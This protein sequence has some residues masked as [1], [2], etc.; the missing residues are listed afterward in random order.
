M[1]TR[2]T[3]HLDRLYREREERY[4]AGVL[5][6]VLGIS[7]AGN[8]LFPLSLVLAFGGMSF[9]QRI[10]VLASTLCALLNVVGGFLLLY[11]GRRRLAT[12]FF[13]IV[14]WLIITLSSIPF[15]L[16]GGWAAAVPMMIV[17]AAFLLTWK[18]TLALAALFVMSL[19]AI[20][21]LQ[22]Y[23]IPPTPPA[24]SDE[25]I[26]HLGLVVGSTLVTG[27]VVSVLSGQ[28][29]GL[30]EESL[31]WIRRMHAIFAVGKSMSTITDFKEMLLAVV[32]QIQEGFDF[33]HV[34]IFLIQKDGHELVLRASTA[35]DVQQLL[36]VL[37]KPAV[38]KE[39]VIGRAALGKAVIINDVAENSLFSA[40]KH[41]PH[42]QSE[43][44][45]PMMTGGRVLGVLDVMSTSLGTFS[46]EGIR[47]LQA[48]AN[49]IAVAIQTTGEAAPEVAILE[50][51]D[52]VFCASREIVGA[53]DAEA[54]IATLRKRVLTTFDHIS[55]VQFQGGFDEA[56]LEELAVWDRDG[57]APGSETPV[58][59]CSA[60]D[61][62]ALVISNVFDLPEAWA[63]HQI[64]LRDRL[65]LGSVGIFPLRGRA[66]P[67]GYLLVGKRQ[68]H[69][70]SEREHCTLLALSGQIALLLE[71][72]L[73]QQ[74]FQ[75]RT[76]RLNRLNAFF[77][78]VVAVANMD[79]LFGVL[80]AHLASMIDYRYL[81]LT[82]QESE[83]TDARTVQLR[84]PDGHPG[85]I[86]TISP[87]GSVIEQALQEEQVIVAT[88]VMDLPDGDIWLMVGVRALAIAP[89]KTEEGTLGTVNVGREEADS[90]VPEEAALLGRVGAQVA[91]AIRN[92]RLLDQTQASM[93]DITSLLLASQ[94][95]LAADGSDDII[96]AF[97]EMLSGKAAVD[98][99]I[100]LQGSEE[101][102]SHFEVT[103]VWN[104]TEE[105]AQL[106]GKVGERYPIESLP[107]FIQGQD[108]CEP[109]FCASIEDDPRLNES[110]R[111][112]LRGMGVQSMIRLPMRRGQLWLGEALLISCG[113]ASLMDADVKLYQTIVDQATFAL[114]NARLVDR[115]SASVVEATMLYST[116]LSVSIAK[117]VEEIVEVALSQLVTLNDSTRGYL[118]L[119]PP[120]PTLRSEKI[121]L[122]AWWDEGQIHWPET[123]TYVAPTSVPVLGAVAPDTG[124][125]I[126]NNAA[127]DDLLSEAVREALRAR[128][129]E[130][131]AVLHL[132]AG[133]DWMGTV[134][135]EGGEG[136]V[137]S[138]D[139]IELCRG[140][141]DLC[142][143]A[144]NLQVALGYS[145][146]MAT[147]EQILRTISDRI[148]SAPDVESVLRIAVEELGRV[149]NVEEGA[150][151]LKGG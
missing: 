15:G 76:E 50:A 39:S 136:H 13:L 123:E 101:I 19:I 46:G 37:D 77:E 47:A 41:F 151:Q 145:R 44:A 21:L 68:P 121:H 126:F 16:G 5:L 56:T 71:N 117:S 3:D 11:A 7:V 143:L 107:F 137:F 146:G 87:P 64:F 14:Q 70:F 29:A 72:G 34:Q 120:D 147:Q 119:T 60:A 85:I 122:A 139:M 55:L 48:L 82:L 79:D 111:A 57:A 135:L 113:G 52:P 150:A 144:L 133:V 80:V 109:T 23:N 35:P 96:R 114:E 140:I 90:F 86:E 74:E 69:V 9:A 28:I 20:G 2:L 91:A 30:V 59:L 45:L 130:V 10:A 93:E 26:L 25:I 131:V 17:L 116:S 92:I 124:Y 58:A 49:Q 105:Y 83:Q 63:E 108:P 88:D 1:L 18:G 138:E 148:R 103:S 141:A 31:R 22:V 4:R 43:A 134:V 128:G 42:T 40:E 100:I 65:A 6:M 24:T 8:L 132:S 32:E 75:A 78:A 61:E 97:T 62:E 89:L 99:V 81:S 115:L 149:L 127:N 102:S 33:Y 98:R 94:H 142:G 125:H 106:D 38:G 73:I 112:A 67:I 27:S 110:A 51:L 54:I 104:S 36:R 84:S 12:W 129:V 66:L 118:Y 95:M 53:P